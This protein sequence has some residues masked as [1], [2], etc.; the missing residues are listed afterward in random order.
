MLRETWEGLVPA[1]RPPGCVLRLVA[2][3]LWARGWESTW[4]S[5]GDKLGA[6]VRT[7][8]GP[9]VREHPWCPGARARLG[10]TVL[11]TAWRTVVGPLPAR[12][13][14][15]YGRVPSEHV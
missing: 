4:I 13:P 2:P 5:G 14:R 1:S 8:L 10:A 11:I 3:G 15:A 7:C 6:A 12:H 9:C